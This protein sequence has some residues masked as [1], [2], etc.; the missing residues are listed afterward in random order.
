[1]HSF[2]SAT[3]VKLNMIMQIL[4]WIDAQAA[5]HTLAPIAFGL[6]TIA[7]RAGVAISQK[8]RLNAVVVAVLEGLSNRDL[9]RSAKQ[10]TN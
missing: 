1:V 9:G 2:A 6:L 4:N 10:T 3:V 7:T 5:V 8:R